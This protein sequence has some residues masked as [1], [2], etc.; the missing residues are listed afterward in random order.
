[1]NLKFSQRF[2]WIHLFQTFNMFEKLRTIFIMI[3]GVLHECIVFK[4]PSAH[5][6][7]MT[8]N[9]KMRRL[10]F[11]LRVLNLKWMALKHKI[12]IRSYII[13]TN[14]VN[15]RCSAC[16]SMKISWVFRIAHSTI[17][18]YFFNLLALTLM[19]IKKTPQ[20]L[21]LAQEAFDLFHHA[22]IVMFFYSLTK[23]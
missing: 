17:R 23:L 13:T 9:I 11:D 22:N 2:R 15:R 18:A 10:K 4:A 1:M 6:F 12:F 14:I 3:F 21:L 16:C 7:I 8:A 19:F 20:Q 5:W